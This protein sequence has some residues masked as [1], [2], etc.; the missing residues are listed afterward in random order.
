MEVLA[1]AIMLLRMLK[2]AHAGF[3]LPF[4]APTFQG[5]VL[6]DWSRPRRTL[7][8]QAEPSG[9]SVVGTLTLANGEKEYFTAHS[10][11]SGSGILKYY[12]WFRDDYLVWPIE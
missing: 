8:V 7:E 11:Q 4:I 6:L 5:Y 10:D 9:W 1:K 2:Q 12:E 3:V